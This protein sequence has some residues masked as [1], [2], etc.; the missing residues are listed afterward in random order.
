MQDPLPRPPG[1]DFCPS[2]ICRYCL[3]LSDFIS[4]WQ[5]YQE[6]IAQQKSRPLERPARKYTFSAAID[7]Y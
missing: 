4:L 1:G 5:K 6:N 2:N 7:T 3:P